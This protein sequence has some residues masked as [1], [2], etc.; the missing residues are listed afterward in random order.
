MYPDESE[1]KDAIAAGAFP[2]LEVLDLFSLVMRAGLFL[3][4]Q[5]N[6]SADGCMEAA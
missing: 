4:V 1:P 3:E 6:G 2:L 5:G